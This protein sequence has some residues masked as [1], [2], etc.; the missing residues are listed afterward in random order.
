MPATHPE[1]PHWDAARVQHYWG[2]LIVSAGAHD[3]Y[4]NHHCPSCDQPLAGDRYLATAHHPI[5]RE[6]HDDIRICGDC[7]IYLEY[8]T[9]PW[10]DASLPTQPPRT[11]AAI[12]AHP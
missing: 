12:G 10:Q 1:H 9:H 6:H 5:T 2:D 11:P 7:L 8:G 4:S 3:G